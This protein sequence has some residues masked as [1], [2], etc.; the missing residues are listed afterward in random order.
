[1]LPVS[2]RRRCSTHPLRCDDSEFVVLANPCSDRREAC[3]T[4]AND[5]YVI[6]TVGIDRPYQPDA[7]GEFS[8]ARIAQQLSARAQHDRQLTRIDLK[9]L[10]KR[11]GGRIGFG[12]E[13]LM[14]MAVAAKKALQAEHVGVLRTADD[15]GPAGPRL[16]E[17]DVEGEWVKFIDAIKTSKKPRPAGLNSPA[18]PHATAS[19]DPDRR[20]ARN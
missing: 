4:G 19:S 16:Q 10:D 13:A 1:V 12:I 11:L 2:Y 17:T 18:G 8:L 5:R 20:M 9:S 6:D 3:R 14:R 7:A 15:H